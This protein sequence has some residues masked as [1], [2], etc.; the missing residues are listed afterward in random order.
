[1]ICRFATYEVKK[2]SL[3]AAIAAV[4][5]YV[6]EVGRKEGGTATY[7]AYHHEG[8]GRFTHYMEFRTPSAMDYHQKTAW[9]KRFHETILPH[10]LAPPAYATVTPVLGA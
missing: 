3:P 2:E 5:S 8:T 4:A 10:C 7:K 9:S 1:M 6:D